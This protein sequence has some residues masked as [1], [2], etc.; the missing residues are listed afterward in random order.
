MK[1]F[2]CSGSSRGGFGFR[3]IREVDMSPKNLPEDMDVE[4]S[5]ERLG[6]FVTEEDPVLLRPLSGGGYALLLHLEEGVSLP[7]L[8]LLAA[9]AS[10]CQVIQQALLSQPSKPPKP[11]LSDESFDR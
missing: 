8:V 2:D 4:R 7:N 1:R 11:S 9:C 3:G 6:F 10:R 5:L